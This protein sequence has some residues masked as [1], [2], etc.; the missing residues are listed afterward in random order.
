MDGNDTIYKHENV[1]TVHVLYV[2]FPTR[3]NRVLACV[4]DRPVH[5]HTR[6]RSTHNA[7]T[8]TS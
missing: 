7:Y 1:L 3:N 8:H 6:T 4:I 5:T 2:S